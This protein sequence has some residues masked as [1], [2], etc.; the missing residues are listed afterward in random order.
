MP[1]GDIAKLRTSAENAKEYLRN[2]AE[3]EAKG[4]Y[5]PLMAKY[6][7]PDMA[8]YS[9]IGENGQGVWDK[10]SPTPF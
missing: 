5:N 3:L 4:L 6:D 2:K 8:T 1:Y 7:G 9:T 10:M